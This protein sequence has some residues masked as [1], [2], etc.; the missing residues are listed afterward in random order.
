MAGGKAERDGLLQELRE[1]VELLEKDIRA[2][3]DRVSEY[4]AVFETEYRKLVKAARIDGP[5][6]AWRRHR[7][8]QVAAGWVLAT[9]FVRFCEDNGLIEQPW[10]AGPAERLAVA[11]SRHAAFLG[12]SPDRGD[13]DWLIAAFDHLAACHPAM[14]TLLNREHNPLWQL[15]PS[16]KAAS[17]LLGFWRRRDSS[18]EPVHSFVDADLD[19]GFLAH[20]YQDL[21][22][23]ARRAYALSHTHEAAEELVLDLTLEPAIEEFGLEPEL[24]V[25]DADAAVIW[26]HV[27]LRTIDPACGS[28]GF[29]L[30]LFR[31]ILRKHR[32]AAESDTAAGCSVDDWALIRTALNSV[33]GCDT[34]PFAVAI[35]RF[36][37]LVAVL[38]EAGLRRL[39]EA[40]EFALN[41]AVGDALLHG[42]GVL[43]NTNTPPVAT[44]KKRFFHTTEDVWAYSETVDLLGVNSYHVTVASP[45]AG[46][47][48]DERDREKH[49]SAYDVCPDDHSPVPLFSQ[50][51]FELATRD[52]G[53][54]SGQLAANHFMKR[55][56]G[57]KLVE[58]F[59]SRRVKLTH[60]LDTSGA[61]TTGDDKPT[62]ILAGRNTV[63]GWDA[64]VRVAL[65]IQREP[66]NPDSTAS[67]A[68]GAVLRAIAEQID[69]PET[70][71]EWVSVHDFD[72]GFFAGHP[73]SLPE[74]GGT[75]PERD[76]AKAAARLLS[77]LTED[78]G[79]YATLRESGAYVVGRAEAGRK[80]LFP[81]HVRP[82]VDTVF[83]GDWVLPDDTYAVFPYTDHGRT[84]AV[85]PA[86]ERFLWPNRT[87]LESRHEL[88]PAREA[89]DRAWFEY[90]KLSLDKHDCP[91]LIPFSFTA[92][93]NHFFL[94]RGERI[95]GH[96]TPVIQ[97]KAGTSED[98]HL[99]LVGLL[100]SSAACFW[101]KQTSRDRGKQ[102]G[103]RDFA[104]ENWE[105][106]YEFTADTLDDF[107][108]PPALPLE[109]GTY[110]DLFAQELAAHEPAAV[111]ASAAPTRERLDAA[112]A[113]H[114]SARQWMIALQEELDWQVYGLYGL[115]DEDETAALVSPDVDEVPEVD[116]G[117]RAF[118]IVLARQVAAGEKETSW[119][120]RHGST[121][122][123]EIPERWPD[124]YREIV[125][126]RV[127]TIERHRAIGRIE[128]PEYKRRWS[129]EEWEAKQHRAVRG[130]LLDR[131]E[132]P[133]LWFH[134][135]DGRDAAPRAM[136]VAELADALTRAADAA[137]VIAVAELYAADHLGRP[138]SGLADVLH[139]ITADQHVPSPAALRYTETGMDTRARWEEV[140]EQQREQDRTGRR[141][142]LPA[143]PR[144]GPDD[145]RDPSYWR[146]RGTLDVPR[147]RFI[148]YP[149]AGPAAEPVLGW[150]GW[151]H[152][153]RAEALMNLTTDRAGTDGRP[154]ERVAPLLAGAR[155]LL[156]WLEQ[157]H[158][159][160]DEE[161]DAQPAAAVREWLARQY[162]RHQLTEES[163]REWR[164][165]PAARRGTAVS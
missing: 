77:D 152:R 4:Q 81:E 72:R 21:S 10:L 67:A 95:F 96:S 113:S 84:A 159:E 20:I 8:T 110:L 27:G 15:P 28:G 5:Y 129:T 51:L 25:R 126:A 79:G 98:E 149:D 120:E 54:F 100:N 78:I 139:E 101:L 136:T 85:T 165:A 12:E 148:S 144:Y 55:E 36:R 82:I 59:L 132:E 163:V 34:N 64:P 162:E 9:L 65:G 91:F 3:N 127:E 102:L 76:M 66:G 30:G 23:P 151:N 119:F 111:A 94:D 99:S 135:R 6:E 138:H 2:R 145:F 104:R 83:I 105:R 92:T 150:A 38:D 121:P 107:P 164:P 140:W 153:Q 44:N 130:W 42:R 142:R 93:H 158:G 53:G 75:A 16:D 128:R 31:R 147:E 103:G 70:E 11:E 88:S 141:T 47:I 58:D 80:G 40:P 125:R 157:W 61:Y 114:T 69:N 155:E 160:H 48:V 73:L 161:W 33:H 146:N 112:H 41:V 123:T 60:V 17:E 118:E 18:G 87:P 116:L 56:Y 143:P 90:A 117:E 68:E 39:D 62:V 50:R 57:K 109:P 37:L 19:T 43:G 14:A 7:I 26:R 63:Y 1:Q 29:L 156:P 49:R 115:F 131:C 22:D 122:V 13:R 133:S 97:L 106:P 74:G 24:E 35:A 134:S 137:D 45:P 86:A 52:D 32:Q 46:G 154:L 124:W 89:P 71:S 108:L